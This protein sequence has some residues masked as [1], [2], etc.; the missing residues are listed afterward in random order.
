[1]IASV[2]SWNLNAFTGMI[3]V[4]MHMLSQTVFTSAATSENLPLVSRY[5]LS[6]PSMALMPFSTGSLVAPRLAMWTC[7]YS[8]IIS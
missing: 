2:I 1:M 3:S 6:I 7:I 4:C 5:T 8:Q